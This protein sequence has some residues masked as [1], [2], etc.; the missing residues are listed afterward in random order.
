VGINVSKV[1]KVGNV[2]VVGMEVGKYVRHLLGAG[3]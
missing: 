3:Y 2:L 1:S